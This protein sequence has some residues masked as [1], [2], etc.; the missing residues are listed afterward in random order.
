MAISGIRNPDTCE[1][2]R[3]TLYSIARRCGTRTRDPYSAYGVGSP[4][5]PAKAER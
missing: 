2:Y 1:S 4:S 5:D 3:H